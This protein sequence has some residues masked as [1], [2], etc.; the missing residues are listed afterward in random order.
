MPWIDDLMDN[1]SG[2]KYFSSIDLA[3]GYHQLCLKESDVP[4]TAFYTYIGKFEW[5]VMPFGLTN[6]PAVCQA[7]MNEIFAKYLNRWLCVYLDDILI[8]S[9]TEEEHMAHIDTVLRLLQEKIS[10][11]H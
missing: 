11:A 5:R 6:A 8:F 7:A 10:C 2:A 4:K 9:K 1:L 3:S